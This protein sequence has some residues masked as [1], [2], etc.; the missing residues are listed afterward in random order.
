MEEKIKILLVDDEPDFVEPLAF[1]LRAKGYGVSIASNGEKA[2]QLVKEQPPNVMF[3]DIKMPGING[4]ETLRRIREFNQD[5]P[6]FMLTAYPEG[7]EFLGYL[8]VSGFFLKDEDAEKLRN[9][10]QSAINSCKNSQ[11]NP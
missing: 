7:K 9:T 6:V 10:I 8:K 1:W 3:L 4:I 11:G 2:I 5:L